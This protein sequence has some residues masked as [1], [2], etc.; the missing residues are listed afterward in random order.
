MEVTRLPIAVP[1]VIEPL[2]E[3][4]SLKVNAELPHEFF[5]LPALTQI[6]VLNGL[7]EAIKKSLTTGSVPTALSINELLQ[8]NHIFPLKIGLACILTMQQSTD[9]KA[10]L[11]LSVTLQMPEAVAILAAIKLNFIKVS[12]MNALQNMM[13]VIV[14]REVNIDAKG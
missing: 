2:I 9:G 3:E 8:Q 7:F 4:Q 11:Q 6:S 13:L 14:N 1:L 10:Q 12:L 5:G